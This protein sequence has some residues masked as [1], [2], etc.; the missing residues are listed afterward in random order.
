M[1]LFQLRTGERYSLE[2]P[3][4]VRRQNSVSLLAGITS[5]LSMAGVR[6][7]AETSL[8]VGTALEFE[9]ALP[10]EVTGGATGVIHGY[11]R[12]V[13]SDDLALAGQAGKSG[14]ACVIDSYEFVRVDKILGKGG[15]TT[16]IS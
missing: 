3:M 8:E 10:E 13:R 12:V 4:T 5:D 16:C 15:T 7:S 6:F 14:L 2:L 9:I 1:A 11:G